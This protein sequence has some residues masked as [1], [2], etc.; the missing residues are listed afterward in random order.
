MQNK[1]LE[2]SCYVCGAGAFGVFFRW[3]QDQ[4]AFNDAG[5][6]D[7]SVLH[8]IVVLYIIA[9]AILFIRFVDKARNKRYYL[10][11]ELNEALYNEG[12]LFTIARWAIGGIMVLGALVLLA[13]CEVEKQAALLKLLALSGILSG[14][15]YPLLLTLANRPVE[16][17]GIAC[18]LSFMPI[19]TFSIWLIV[20]YKMNDINSVVWAYSI[21]IIAVIVAMCAF[22]RMAG[23]SFG[24]PS[25]FR[26]MF[27]SMMGACM[28]IMAIADKR[29]MGM[30]IMLFSAAMMLVL[31]NWI[32]LCNLRRRVAPPKVRPDD[33]F[34]R[35]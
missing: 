1:A 16:H 15:S 11:D 12:K 17:P 24:A 7:R 30:Q 3:L 31:Y 6:A 21:E 29:N 4:M 35:F 22:F 32:M 8:I 20:C 19:L 27:F 2:I 10:P 13:T 23:F 26:A 14:I 25:G 33:G 9:A 5:L 28:C 34:D 18:L